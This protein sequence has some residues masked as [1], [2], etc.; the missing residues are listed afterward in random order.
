MLYLIFESPISARKN[1]KFKCLSGNGASNI[2]SLHLFVRKIDRPSLN[3]SQCGQSAS[4]EIPLGNVCI[5][6]TL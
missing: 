2:L 6:V 5:P 4:T 1:Y 3:S